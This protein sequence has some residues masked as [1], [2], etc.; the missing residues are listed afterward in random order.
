MRPKSKNI[1]PEF[2]SNEPQA[3]SKNEKH[4]KNLQQY[5]ELYKTFDD[6]LTK[7][8]EMEELAHADLRTLCKQ[9]PSR[10]RT[11]DFTTQNLFRAVLVVK[12]ETLSFVRAE[13]AIGVN[14]VLQNFCRL[15]KKDT[16]SAQLIDQASLALSPE[17][18]QNINRVFAHRMVQEAKINPERIRTDGT[19]VE[20]NIHWPTDSSLC[21]DCCRTIGR[22]VENARKAGLSRILAGFRFHV[23]KIKALNFSINKNASAKSKDRQQQCRR[24]YDTII[25]RTE[26]YI[27]NAE[28]IAQLLKKNGSL[29]AM[30]FEAELSHYLPYM[31][32]IADVARRRFR[33]EKVENEEKIFSLFEPHTE[34]I[35]KGKKNKPIEFGHLIVVS[36]TPEKFITDCIVTE[37]SPPESTMVPTVIKNHEEIFGAKPL[38]LAADKGFHP[39]KEEMEDLRDEYEGEVEFLGIPSRSND[40]GDEEMRLYQ[41]FRAGI[42]GTISFLK[43]CF[44]LTRV[45]F[46]GFKGF[47]REVALS[48]FCHNL[49]VMARQDLSPE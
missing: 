35:K 33:G 43:R 24:D 39:G 8:P 13:V 9:N 25:E 23:P 2:F 38:G 29:K 6:Y 31:K 7:Y 12:L 49:T 36:Q 37:V 45:R 5:R 3:E 41:R 21:Y 26:N 14:S 16:I 44:G 27:A 32:K 42:E 40:F 22:I 1:F 28:K 11:P 30:A 15:D 19:V 34:L 17:T 46:K 20:S 18:W 4:T 47:C 10:E 48:V